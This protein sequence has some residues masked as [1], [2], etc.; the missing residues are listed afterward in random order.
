MVNLKECIE[1]MD[2]RGLASQGTAELQLLMGMVDTLKDPLGT[3]RAGRQRRKH[4]GRR[5]SERI[6]GHEERETPRLRP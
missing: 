5:W 2:D 1:S 3:L 4:R 6:G